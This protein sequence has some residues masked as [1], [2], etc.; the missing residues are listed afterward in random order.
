MMV[1]SAL[2]L[3]TVQVT[4][5]GCPEC[6]EHISTGGIRRAFRVVLQPSSGESEQPAVFPSRLLRRWML[7]YL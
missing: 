6:L 7:G 5:T 4:S 3:V 1:A 2:Q